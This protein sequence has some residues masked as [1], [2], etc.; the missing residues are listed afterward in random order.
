[1]SGG[2]CGGRGGRAAAGRAGGRRGWPL[3]GRGGWV[4]WPGREPGR[5]GCRPAPPAPGLP[6]PRG[7]GESRRQPR[8]GG[9]FPGPGALLSRRVVKRPGPC[10]RS[11]AW[12][13]W[14][15]G[16]GEA[17]RAGRA[18]AGD[19]GGGVAAE[20]KRNRLPRT[21]R[22]QRLPPSSPLASAC[23]RL[24]GWLPRPPEAEEFPRGCHR[25]VSRQRRGDGGPALAV[26]L[27]VRPRRA[28]WL[29]RAS[30]HR[31]TV[32]SSVS[33]WL[34]GLSCGLGLLP[35]DQLARGGRRG[36][37]GRQSRASNYF[38]TSFSDPYL[39]FLTPSPSSES[40]WLHFPKSK[41]S[42]SLDS[43]TFMVLAL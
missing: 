5:G 31:G 21:G 17:P 35:G 4:S 36:R 32:D 19:T 39:I 9:P 33:R 34:L 15:L 28:P 12:A 22:G 23:W 37:A 6:P 27:H 11:G 30:W 24:L 20:R 3:R 1:M 26:W 8:P 40:A 16:S 7:W 14:D 38:I 41:L 18:P 13:W 10:G 25:W 42:R 2:A 29:P 43:V